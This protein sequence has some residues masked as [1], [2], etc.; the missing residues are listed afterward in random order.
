MQPRMWEAKDR[1]F[2]LLGIW[3][4]LETAWNQKEG[5]GS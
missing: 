2:N 3:L 4:W 5:L 1:V